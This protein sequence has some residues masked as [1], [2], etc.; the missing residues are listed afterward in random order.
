MIDYIN[1]IYWLSTDALALMLT[2]EDDPAKRA[3]LQREIE[4]RQ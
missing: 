2:H 4:A 1:F 3:I